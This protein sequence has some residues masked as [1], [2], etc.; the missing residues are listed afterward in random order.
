MD[1]K[2]AKTVTVANCDINFLSFLIII[3]INYYRP[4]DIWCPDCGSKPDLHYIKQNS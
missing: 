3:G 2:N 4:Q 1:W